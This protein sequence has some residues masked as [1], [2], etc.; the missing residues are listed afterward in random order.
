MVE[1][2]ELLDELSK[3]A[4]YITNQAAR[5]HS[6]YNRRLARERAAGVREAAH[7]VLVV[8][9]RQMLRQKEKENDRI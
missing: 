5:D 3:H 7:L 2:T 1:H 4:E 9:E 6:P 8:A